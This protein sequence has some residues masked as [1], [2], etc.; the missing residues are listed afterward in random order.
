MVVV[1]HLEDKVITRNIILPYICEGAQGKGALHQVVKL[2]TQ[3]EQNTGIV[4]EQLYQLQ[5]I[6][7]LNSQM[8]K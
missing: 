6:S 5:H 3:R 8:M 4:T 7:Y 2:T 1:K